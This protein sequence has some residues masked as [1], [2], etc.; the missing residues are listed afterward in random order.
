MTENIGS[1][2]RRR[3][4]ICRRLTRIERDLASLETKEDLVHLDQSKVERLLG[5]NKEIDANFEMRHLEVLDLIEEEDQYTLKQE[6]E[7]FDEHVSKMAELG[8]D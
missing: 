4:L 6:E 3:G 2:R 5:Q 7:V 1:A 8:K